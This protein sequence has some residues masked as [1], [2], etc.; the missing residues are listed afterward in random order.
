[1]K[2]PLVLLQQEVIF[3]ANPKSPPK[4]HKIRA[5]QD[6]QKLHRFQ[7][8]IYPL[9]APL[10]YFKDLL[11]NMAILYKYV[12]KNSKLFDGIFLHPSCNSTY[13]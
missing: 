6:A 4:E 11:D 10:F 5:F 3:G 1:M 7:G 9:K 12:S 2:V 13:L 8:M